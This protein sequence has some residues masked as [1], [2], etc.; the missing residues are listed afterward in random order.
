MPV[1]VTLPA[2]LAA[3]LG[4]GWT[5]PLEDTFGEFQL[6]IWLRENGV[7]P[8]DATKAAAGWGGDRLAVMEGPSGAWAVAIHTEWDTDA[9]A[10]EFETAA[11]AALKKA[12]GV[13]RLL[14][15]LGGKTRWV[16]VAGDATPVGSLTSWAAGRVL[17]GP[18][19][20]VLR[21]RAGGS[22]GPRGRVC[23]PGRAVL[24]ARAG[25]GGSRVQSG[26][27]GPRPGRPC[28]MTV[29]AI[30][31]DQTGPTGRD[32]RPG[33]AGLAREG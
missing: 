13:A 14:P 6:G 15:G 11:T 1:P 18:G 17:C 5:V 28:P 9:E 32:P 7:A 20:R 12:G 30:S 10:T 3:R 8:A 16:L 24:R 27:R 31:S 4:T 33:R 29:M 21:A 19:G 23:G 2:D 26:F 25:Q 22:C